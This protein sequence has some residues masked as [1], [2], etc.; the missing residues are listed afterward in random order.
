MT[1]SS[2]LSAP[3]QESGSKRV[4]KWFDALPS[5]YTPDPQGVDQ[6]L[7]L[8]I[9]TRPRVRE[10]LRDEAV[11]SAVDQAVMNASQICSPAVAV[12]RG[13]RL[14]IDACWASRVLAPG[15]PLSPRSLSD[16]GSRTEKIRDLL[17]AAKAAQK[18]GQRLTSLT[19]KSLTVDH[20]ASRLQAG[21][22]A[23]F[24]HRRKRTT[25]ASQQT[26]SPHISAL[27][28]TLAWELAE[29]ATL[30]N[31]DIAESRQTQ[32]SRRGANL[33]I[34]RLLQRSLNLGST[35]RQGNPVP[36]FDLVHTVVTSLHPD[37]SLDASTARKRWE[38]LHRKTQA[39]K[40]L[41]PP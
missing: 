16:A 23:L 3:I 7:A 19:E 17:A 35:N 9:P 31:L 34:D 12:E 11:A 27:L 40:S 25:A 30:L 29:E 33:L 20:L 5:Q 28:E 38:K 14:L 36:S 26:N 21:N 15:T 41:S 8:A 1:Q 2:K 37:L 10:L 4:K 13:A 18:L 24:V 39:Q 22:S 6:L 32:S